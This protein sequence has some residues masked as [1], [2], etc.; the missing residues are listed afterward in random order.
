VTRF[1][2]GRPSHRARWQQAVVVVR[3]GFADRLVHADPAGRQVQVHP[4]DTSAPQRQN[5]NL[6]TGQLQGSQ[7]ND[8]LN[9]FEAVGRQDGN[10]AALE[11]ASVGHVVL[12]SLDGAAE[13]A[14]LPPGGSFSRGARSCSSRWL[15]AEPI[16]GYPY[17]TYPT[18]WWTNRRPRPR[19]Y[20]SFGRV[21]QT[22]QRQDPVKG[23]PADALLCEC[24]ECSECSECNSPVRN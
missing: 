18:P 14:S 9:L 2:P 3:I 11:P 6:R 1:R 10:F 7:R 22:V 23:R 8:E 5:V 12:P 17:P 24:S 13:A 20:S 21:C 4:A 15:A 19:A 16:G